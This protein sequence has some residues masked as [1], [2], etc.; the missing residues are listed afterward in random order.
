MFRE[1]KI[2]QLQEILINCWPGYHYFFLNGWILRFTDG[3]TARANSVFP[4]NYH[5]KPKDLDRDLNLVEK[6]Y[7]AYKLPAIFTI[8]EVFEPHNLDLKLKERGYQ[9]FGCITYVMIISIENLRDEVINEEFTY[10]F[11]T[12]RVEEIS[13]FL[14]KYSKRNKEEQKV[15][16]A[17]TNRIVIPKKCFIVAKYVNKIVGTLLG[18]LDP[19]G[20]LY[21]VDVLVHPNFRKQKI[22]TSMLFKIIKNWGISNGIEKIWLQ[23]EI[24]NQE[25][26]NL[27]TKL[28]FKKLYSYYYLKKN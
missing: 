7:Q 28:G 17:L 5:G 25:A 21:I 16:D 4:L 10:I 27:Y 3:V 19:H 6:A 9:Q 14:V 1:E 20:Y 24:E 13:N 15:L 8:P 11:H 18:I 26:L 22:A 23:V 12:K 2:K